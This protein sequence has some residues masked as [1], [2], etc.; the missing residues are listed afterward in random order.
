MLKNEKVGERWSHA[1]PRK[2]SGAIPVSY[3]EAVTRSFNACSGALDWLEATE[4]A[5]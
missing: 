4:A 3:F 5:R 1:A 2:V